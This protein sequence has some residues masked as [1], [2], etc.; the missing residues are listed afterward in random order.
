[1]DK[2]VASIEGGKAR[3]KLGLHNR[4]EVVF[5][6]ADCGAP[7]M[8]MLITMNNEDLVAQGVDPVN[9]RIQ[10]QCGCGGRSYVQTVEGCFHPGAAADDIAFD[11]V[12]NDDE[13]LTVFRAW[14]K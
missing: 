14:R 2:P 8:K 7:L 6:C 5:D 13:T 10:V 12:P 3:Q 9:T 11:V 4:G 1:M